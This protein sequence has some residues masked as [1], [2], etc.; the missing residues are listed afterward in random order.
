MVNNYAKIGRVLSHLKSLQADI[1]FLQETHLLTD[2]HGRLKCKWVDQIYH[3][4]FSTNASGTAILVHK[5]VAFIYIIRQKWTIHN[6]CGGT[7]L[8]AFNVIEYI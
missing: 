6:G 4:K 8:C 3:S 5:G 7:T 1:M 2:V